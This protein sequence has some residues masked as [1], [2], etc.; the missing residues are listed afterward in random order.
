M[1]HF[2][3]VSP[4]TYCLLILGNDIFNR[5]V[6][7]IIG[8]NDSYGALSI[9]YKDTLDVMP[10]RTLTLEERTRRDKAFAPTGLVASG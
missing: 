1:P 4:D 7:E 3:Y 5:E 2:A 9:R 10:F 6:V 8:E